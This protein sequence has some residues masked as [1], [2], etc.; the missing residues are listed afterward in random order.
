MDEEKI[1]TEIEHPKLDKFY[2]L[3]YSFRLYSFLVSSAIALSSF[4]LFI[5]DAFTGYVGQTALNIIAICLGCSIFVPLT[6]I[7]VSTIF[8]FRKVKS[9]GLI[10]DKWNSRISSDDDM[11]MGG[12]MLVSY[13]VVFIS[14]IE[15]IST[16]LPIHVKLIEI[17][18]M[19]I[20]YIL[21]FVA[22]FKS[23]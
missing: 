13:I 21:L 23:L 19:L 16:H 18:I 8:I 7:Y 11:S 2:R 15:I 12:D 6:I 1:K 9:D 17:A 10:S 22:R 20:L 3:L 5:Y 4:A 14:S